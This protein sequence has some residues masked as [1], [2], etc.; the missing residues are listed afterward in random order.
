MSDPAAV[1]YASQPENPRVLGRYL[2]ACDAQARQAPPRAARAIYDEAFDLLL[3][4]VSDDCN[5]R[6]WR[7]LCLDHLY[8]PLKALAALADSDTQRQQLREREAR[9]RVLTHYFLP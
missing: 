7:A 1:R 4:A 5:P 8:R 3:D 9:M 6:H 2:D